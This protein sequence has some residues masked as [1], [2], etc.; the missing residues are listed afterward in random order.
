MP[1][2][3]NG[4]EEPH[5][6]S[7]ASPARDEIE[8]LDAELRRLHVTVPRRLLERLQA[9]RDARSHAR[10]EGRSQWPPHD[11]GVCGATCRVEVDHLHRKA[12]GGPPALGNL[13]LRC[14]P[15]DLETARRAF[16]EAWMGRFGGRRGAG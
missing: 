6:A 11:G 8:P 14:Q 4:R 7:Q 15:H 1:P 16:G 12:R 9:A 5:G 3:A 2:P 13:R 10:D